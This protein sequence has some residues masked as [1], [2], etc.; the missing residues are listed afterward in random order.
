MHLP[1]DSGLSIGRNVLLARATTNYVLYV[2]DDFLLGEDSLIFDMLIVAMETGADIV[3]GKIPEDERLYNSDFSGKL[4]VADKTLTL[5]Y[6]DYGAEQGCVL[7]RRG[8]RVV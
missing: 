5:S 7:M 1:F 3:A 8:A 4:M 6:G 2:D